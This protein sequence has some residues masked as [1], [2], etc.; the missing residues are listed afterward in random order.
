MHSNAFAVSYIDY[1][2]LWNIERFLQLNTLSKFKSLTEFP[3]DNCIPIPASAHI[4][5]L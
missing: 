2:I 5:E 1:A 4:F 3:H